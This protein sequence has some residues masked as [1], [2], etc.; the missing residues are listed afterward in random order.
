MHNLLAKTVEREIVRFLD[1]SFFFSHGDNNYAEELI[2]A[3]TAN[4]YVETAEGKADSLHLKIKECNWENFLGVYQKIIKSYIKR[5]NIRN[6]ILAFDTTAE[7]FYGKTNGLYFIGCECKE[8]YKQ[9][10]EFLVVS[11]INENKGEKIPLACIP[12]HLGFDC[13]KA[14]KNLL[15]YA[16]KL[17]RIR[18]VLLDR[19]FYSAENIN[20]L[21]GFRYLMLIPKLSS[22]VKYYSDIVCSDVHFHQK[23]KGSNGI[24]AITRII[25]VRDKSDEFTW[26]FSTN[27]IMNDAYDYVWL[28]KKRW[29][30]ETNFRVE[31][32]AKIKSKSIFPVIRYFYF[33]IGLLLHSIWLL[34]RKEI[35]FKA[36]LIQTYK[37]II[38]QAL[39]IDQISSC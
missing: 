16:N 30:I 1:K 37:Q 22:K 26:S 5:L 29:R 6:G 27:I 31:D 17:F 11:L 3:A 4:T 34:F 9:E 23:V 33:T 38:F 35:P 39:N 19:G 21:S 18:F 25:L 12:V 2:L 36:F 24:E 8:G 13:A 7:P 32:E 10:F 15:A 20:A 28:Y 14:I